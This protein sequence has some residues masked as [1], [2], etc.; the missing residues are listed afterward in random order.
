MNTDKAGAPNGAAGPALCT[1][2]R[3]QFRPKRRVLVYPGSTVIRYSAKNVALQALTA[4]SADQSEKDHGRDGDHD[5]IQAGKIT[6]E[7]VSH[8]A[9]SLKLYY[10][11]APRDDKHYFTKHCSGGN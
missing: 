7:H 9:F 11:A 1:A 4:A 10:E 2:F 8:L 3:V 5:D 6:I